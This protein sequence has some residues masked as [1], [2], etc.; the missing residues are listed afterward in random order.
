LDERP[1][2]ILV[3]DKTEDEAKHQNTTMMRQVQQKDVLTPSISAFF[4][5]FTWHF[6]DG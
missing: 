1:D 5:S 6:Y 2:L 4:D 3:G